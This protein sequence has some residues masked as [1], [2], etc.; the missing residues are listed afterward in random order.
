MYVGLQTFTYIAY[1]NL[2]DTYINIINSTVQ[3]II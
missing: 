3:K 2:I 1:S